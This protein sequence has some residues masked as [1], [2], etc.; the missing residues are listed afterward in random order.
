MTPRA[1]SALA[2][3]TW[4]NRPAPTGSRYPVGGWGSART[5]IVQAK[6]ASARPSETR[7]RTTWVPTFEPWNT[8][9]DDEPPTDSPSTSHEY[10]RRSPSGSEA[11]TTSVSASP[12]PRTMLAC[13][14]AE[15]IEGPRFPI[16]IDPAT[17]STAPRSSATASRT[18]NVPLFA[19]AWV[20]DTPAP[21][22]PSPKSQA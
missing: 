3:S 13:G 7:T 22:C 8:Y 12:G 20:T 9:A 21:V 4:T 17:L 18:V 14:L 2:E 1:T 15:T 10:V 19:Y 16:S 6:L 11:T 5:S